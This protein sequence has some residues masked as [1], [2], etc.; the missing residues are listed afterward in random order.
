MYA[1]TNLTRPM[2]WPKIALR[3]MPTFVG[4]PLGGE[5]AKLIVGAV[6]SPA[7]AVAGGA[8]TGAI[9]GLAQWLGFRHTG[10]SAARWIIATAVGFA[11]GLAA[12]AAA[13]DYRTDLASLATQG[14]I[15]GAIVGAAQAAVLYGKLGRLALAWPPVV[16][17]LW[18]L[19]WTIT[20]A[21]GIDVEAQYTVFG[22]SGAIVV[23]A[24]TSVLAIAL[25]R[26]AGRAS[27]WAS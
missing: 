21:A 26:A 23:T 8:I 2:T 11:G 6:D 17:G 15:C 3:W 18:A 19:G 9:L 7:A 4:F 10:P 13:V 1:P 5:A 20:T 22:S 24:G 14:A 27:S 16:A 25:S 12:G